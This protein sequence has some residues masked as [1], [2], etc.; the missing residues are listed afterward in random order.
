V[1]TDAHLGKELA[2]Y[3][4]Q[5]TEMQLIFVQ[6]KL[7]GMTD[8]ASA[9][10]AGLS[11]PQKAGYRFMK[12]KAVQEAVKVGREALARGVMFDRRKAHEMLMD[13]HRNAENATEQV[14]AIRE[15]I[16]LHGIAAPEVKE[17]HQTVKGEVV[18]KEVKELTDEELLRLAKLPTAQL[19]SIIEGEYQELP[20]ANA[21][22][23][24]GGSEARKARSAGAAED[25]EEKS[26]QA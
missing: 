19:P 8:V 3:L 24:D 13:A 7:K 11:N 16:K 6:C 17:I 21:T 5:L 2:P 26:E 14:V 25:A 9:T 1:K 12:S 20:D 18:H 23:E 4:E 10:A 22:R 15:M